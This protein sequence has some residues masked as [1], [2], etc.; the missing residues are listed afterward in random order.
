MSV[1]HYAFY[2]TNEVSKRKL[3]EQIINGELIPGLNSKKVAVFS[4]TTLHDLIHKEQ[5]YGIFELKKKDAKKSLMYYSEGER[6]KALLNYLVAKQPRYLIVD[7]PYDNLDLK[8]QQSIRRQFTTLSKHLGIIQL[9]NRKDE[10]FPFIKRIY[11]L[12][13]MKWVLINTQAI[14]KR[15]DSL[16]GKIPNTHFFEKLDSEVLVKF[17]N[18]NVSYNGIPVLKNISFEIRPQDFWQITGRNGA[19][20]STLLSL[21]TGDN[22]KGYGQNITLFGVKKG[23]GE[24]VW[25]HKRKIGYFSSDMKMGF[26][27]KT[28]LENMLLSGFFDSI[29]LYDKPSKLQIDVAV[30]WLTILGFYDLRKSNFI[31]LTLAQQRMVLIARA[32]IK[33]PPLLLLDEPTAGLDDASVDLVVQLI[34]K[35]HEETKTA[36]VYVSHKKEKGLKPSQILAL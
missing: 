31:F 14:L 33:Q 27:R 11:Q 6:K 35:I 20:K 26:T 19:G 28:T 24:S 21:I 5:R 18:V 25:E 23:S 15:E 36:I 30:Q 16:V 9:S 3:I 1:T 17:K 8:S 32:M 34:R 29:G 2:I 22:V 13:N 12:E 10:L 4:E 7:N